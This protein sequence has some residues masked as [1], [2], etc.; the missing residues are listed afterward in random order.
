MKLF[1]RFGD[2]TVRNEVRQE[3]SDLEKVIDIEKEIIETYK[4]D[5]QFELYPKNENET[6]QLLYK[7]TKEKITDINITPELLQGYIDARD[8]PEENRKALI[9]GMYSAALLEIISTKTPETHTFIDGRGKTFNYLFY[10]IHNVKNLT[11]TNI[12]GNNILRNAG[13]YGGSATHII[14]NNVNGAYILEYAGSYKGSIT[15]IILREIKGYYIF[16]Y[17]G[18]HNG[19]LQNIVLTNVTGDYTLTAAAH[20]G[21][22]KHITLINL[23]GDLTLFNAG[24]CSGNASNI[25]LTNMKGKNILEKAG[26]FNGNL[27]NIL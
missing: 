18:V 25:T 6:Y 27:K 5:E 1:N 11:L 23:K 21:N 13:M 3:K 22:A 16:S 14:L 4:T 12:K 2:V 9:R 10:H 24:S 7:T 17:A 26:S 8:N 15:H 19:N 20:S